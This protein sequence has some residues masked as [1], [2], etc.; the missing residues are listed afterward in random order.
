MW[1]AWQNCT[2]FLGF[3]AREDNFTKKHYQEM[4]YKPLEQ[5]F[6]TTEEQISAIIHPR[7]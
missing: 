6:Q 3:T 7:S 1:K 5:Q 4:E 2:C